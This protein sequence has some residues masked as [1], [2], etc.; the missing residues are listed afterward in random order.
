MVEF[1]M[2]WL[3]LKLSNEASWLDVHP[4]H[5]LSILFQFFS[6]YFFSRNKLVVQI[7]KSWIY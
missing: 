1:F 7:N 4:A 6:Q 2:H 3:C 5:Y